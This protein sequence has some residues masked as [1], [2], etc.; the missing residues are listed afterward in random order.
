MSRNMRIDTGSPLVRRAPVIALLVVLVLLMSG[1]FL[2]VQSPSAA[3]HSA[4][5][6]RSGSRGDSPVLPSGGVVDSSP[7]YANTS[8]PEVPF[9]NASCVYSG[10]SYD[11]SISDT[12]PSTLSLANGNIAVTYQTLTNVSTSACPVASGNA[13]SAIGVAISATNGTS[14]GPAYLIT[15]PSGQACPYYNALEPAFTVSGDEVYGTYVLANAT[16]ASLLPPGILA[17]PPLL[18]YTD[19]SETALAFV[20]SNDNATSF[21]APLLLNV[22]GNISRP[23]I[24][25]FGESVYIVYEN[26]SNGTSSL[27]MGGNGLRASPIALY[28]LR[29]LDGG[30]R[31][32]TPELLPGYLPGSNSTQYNTTMSPA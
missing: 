2:P 13:T 15:D 11:C 22:S 17:G 23:A 31:W 18:P 32:S 24:A 4:S 26:I 7:S 1:L 12:D 14:F 25:A 28:L 5:S 16:A 8:I 10:G 6:G 21:S 19:R 20:D 27:S 3:S 9:S 29:S 30:A